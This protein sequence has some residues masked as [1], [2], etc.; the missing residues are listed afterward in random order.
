M[1]TPIVLSVLLL[2]AVAITPATANWFSN[3][4]EGILRNIGSAPNP[5]P[6]DVRE[7][8]MPIV[9]KDQL[10]PGGSVADASTA[11]KQMTAKTPAHPQSVAAASPPH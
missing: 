11:L 3:P 4:K 8:R 5:T 10:L 1:K 7:N 9:V 6:E 2:S